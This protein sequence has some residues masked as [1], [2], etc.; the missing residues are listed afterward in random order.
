MKKANK[1]NRWKIENKIE[2]NKLA[3]KLN[4]SVAERIELI[5][6]M[7]KK[8]FENLL[9]NKSIENTKLKVWATLI[10][11][12]F[13]TKKQFTDCY[14]EFNKNEVK[15]NP[16]SKKYFNESIQNIFTY[17]TGQ[18]VE[19]IITNLKNDE[20]L[21][22]ILIWLNKKEKKLFHFIFFDDL[23]DI[24]KDF[25]FNEL[26]HS[27]KNLFNF[28]NNIIKKIKNFLNSNVVEELYK[29]KLKLDKIVTNQ[30]K[31]NKDN[32]SNTNISLKEIMNILSSNNVSST[33]IKN[34]MKNIEKTKKNMIDMLMEEFFAEEDDE[35]NTIAGGSGSKKNKKKKKKK[36]AQNCYEAGGY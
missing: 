35:N 27:Y 18:E 7:N 13:I 29:N 9:K 2:S 31:L 11:Y 16:I 36:K 30:Y 24:L 34:E 19:N 22:L 20:I 15:K 10:Q 17:L 4:K 21:E 25:I 6:K 1:I 12:K 26:K 8:I 33:Q 28:H 5:Q 14:T 32:L 23:I 3:S